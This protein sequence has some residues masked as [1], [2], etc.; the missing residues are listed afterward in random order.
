VQSAN[1]P[2]AARRLFF[3]VISKK[4]GWICLSDKTTPVEIIEMTS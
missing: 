4:A 1:V 3:F 2:K